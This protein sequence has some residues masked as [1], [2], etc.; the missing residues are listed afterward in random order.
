MTAV[1]LEDH[2]VKAG[3]SPVG[4]SI[5]GVWRV[6]QLFEGADGVAYAKLAN[7][8][9]GSLTKTLAITALLDTA[10]FRHVG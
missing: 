2:F 4:R 8:A 10:L 6:V 9:D 1:S 5:T 3:R 7:A